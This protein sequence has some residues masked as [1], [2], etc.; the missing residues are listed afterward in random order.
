ATYGIGFAILFSLVA[1]FTYINFR[2]AAPPFGLAPA[3]L[4]AVF[5]VYLVG[6]V[7]TPLSGS[8]IKRFGRRAA[9]AMGI[10]CSVVGLGLTL[11]LSLPV[12][13]VGLAL[14]ATGIFIFQAA[15]TSFLPIAATE[16][17]ASAIGLYIT[18]YYIGGS[19]GAVAPSLLWSQLGWAGCVALVIVAE[20]CALL[21]ALVY[22]RPG[23]RPLP[24][25]T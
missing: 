16:A 1:A 15:A 25:R 24:A 22:W 6:A 17:K 14:A 10:A 8:W 19:I 18:C 5:A 3:A 20:A 21:L 7:V 9:V 4:G 11:V 2:L 13:I 12:V 23:D